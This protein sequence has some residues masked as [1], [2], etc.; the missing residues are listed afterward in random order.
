[1]TSLIDYVAEQFGISPVHLRFNTKSRKRE[2][3]NARQVCMYFMFIEGHKRLIDVAVA[4]NKKEHSTVINAIKKTEDYCDTEPD[5]RD[6]VSHIRDMIRS[7]Q[8]DP[9]VRPLLLQERIISKEHPLPE[10][11]YI[12]LQMAN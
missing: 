5:Y 8:V 7:G 3:K 10:E 1:M 9:V 2:I 11:R 4:F 12:S 6:R